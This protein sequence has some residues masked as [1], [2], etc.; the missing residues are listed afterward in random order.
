MRFDLVLERFVAF[1]GERQLRFAVIG[2]VAM[3]SYGSGR[4]TADLDFVVERSAQS[5]I[6]AYAESIGYETLHASEGYSNHVH[7]DL[8]FGRL[9]FVYVTEATAQKLFA[10]AKQLDVL[11]SLLPIPSPEVL[12]AMKLQAMRNDASRLWSD[13]ADIELLMRC[14]GIDV[15][16]VERQFRRFGFETYYDELRKRN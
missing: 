4:L 2:G 1:F 8:Q 10:S 14:E 9:D 13:L 12:I 16:E 7:P 11:G 5:E 3:Q 6:L 15:S